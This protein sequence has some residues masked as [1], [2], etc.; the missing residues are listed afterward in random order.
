MHTAKQIDMHAYIQLH[1]HTHIICMWFSTRRFFYLGPLALSS[2]AMRCCKSSI[3]VSWACCAQSAR[4]HRSTAWQDSNVKH[5]QD[6]HRGEAFYNSVV[7]A[8]VPAISGMTPKSNQMTFMENGM[9]WG[10]FMQQPRAATPPSPAPISNDVRLVI[11]NM[12]H[13]RCMN[14]VQAERIL[15]RTAALQG[16]YYD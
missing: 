16:P 12:F 2:M 3:A 8:E 4:R 13:L 14:P 11:E 5:G 7:R 15:R 9:A 6:L 1:T 10:G